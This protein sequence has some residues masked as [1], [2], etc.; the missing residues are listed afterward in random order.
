[1]QL[2]AS[3]SKVLQGRALLRP[4]HDD[5]KQKLKKHAAVHLIRIAAAGPSAS[6][7]PSKDV[8]IPKG[9]PCARLPGFLSA[10]VI[11][12]LL[13]IV[14]SSAAAAAAAPGGFLFNITYFHGWFSA[15]ALLLRRYSLHLGFALRIMLQAKHSLPPNTA[16]QTQ[17]KT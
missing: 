8:Q 3:T 2:L 1:M 7:Q 16:D 15:C 5:R 14:L 11:V 12:Q 10:A 9:D 4:H 6:H 13:C 17:G